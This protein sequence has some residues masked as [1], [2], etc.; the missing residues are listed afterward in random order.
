MVKKIALA[1]ALMGCAAATFAGSTN[2]YLGLQGGYSNT[3]YDGNSVRNDFFKNPLNAAGTT[4]QKNDDDGAVGRVY[5]GYQFY[6]YL[7]VEAGYSYFEEM[8]WSHLY[9]VNKAKGDL[10]QQ[11]G[12]LLLK[13][14]L[15]LSRRFELYALGG[16]AY[17]R[18]ASDIN[19]TAKSAGMKDTTESAFR[20]TWG[21]GAQLYFQQYWSVDVSWRRINGGSNL[22]QTDETLIGVSYHFHDPDDD[23]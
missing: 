2:W 7:A 23:F 22:E 18:V 20:P 5:L 17:S 19:N 6:K 3:E 13:P 11:T 14:I 16:V 21:L 4:K 10:Q 1:C 12:D 9:G 15:P 8:D